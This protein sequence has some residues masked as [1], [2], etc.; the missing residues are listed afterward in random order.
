MST[1]ALFVLPSPF[2]V[3][4]VISHNMIDAFIL[5]YLLLFHFP[6]CFVCAWCV[7]S[8]TIQGETGRGHLSISLSPSIFP[9]SRSWLAAVVSWQSFEMKSNGIHCLGSVSQFANHRGSSVNTLWSKS[10]IGRTKCVVTGGGLFGCWGSS[11]GPSSKQ[12]NSKREALLLVV[13]NHHHLFPIPI[14]PFRTLW[15][16][17]MWTAEVLACEGSWSLQRI[18]QQQGGRGSAFK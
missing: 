14:H 15:V 12:V 2:C 13:Q 8:T 18:C 16:N 3:H 9:L 17:S 11:W 6:D 4:L 10:P 7:W 1:A 5:K